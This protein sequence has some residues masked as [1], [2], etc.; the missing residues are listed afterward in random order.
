MSDLGDFLAGL[1][2]P[3]ETKGVIY[4]TVTAVN[5]LTVQFGSDTEVPGLK[6][7]GPY[8]PVVG[9]VVAVWQDGPAR[10]VLGNVS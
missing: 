10:L 4:G 3:G 7:C 8:V 9:H 5:P 1:A 6:K 2:N